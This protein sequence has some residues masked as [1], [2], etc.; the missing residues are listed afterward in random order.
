M[1][2]SSAPIRSSSRRLIS[3]RG[4]RLVRDVGER[5]SAPQLQ[6]RPGVGVRG[7]EQ[8]FEPLGVDGVRR[9]PQLVRAAARDDRAVP[10]QLAQLRDVQ[11]DH[12][13]RARRRMLTPQA[14]GQPRPRSA[15]A[16]GVQR[17][18]RQD[19]PLL[20]RSERHR[21]RVDVASTGPSTPI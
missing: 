11:L 2:A 1:A 18:H 9:D 4:E 19:R 10:E 17:E 8:P 5:R 7:A 13:G 21:R 16:L 20:G 3:A 14:L 6:R 15:R 12:L